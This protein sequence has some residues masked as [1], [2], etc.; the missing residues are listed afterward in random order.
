MRLSWASLNLFMKWMRKNWWWICFWGSKTLFNRP[1]ILKI[2][3]NQSESHYNWRFLKTNT[4][5]VSPVLMKCF[6]ISVSLFFT[7]TGKYFV[8][9]WIVRV[10]ESQCYSR[11]SQVLEMSGIFFFVLDVFNKPVLVW[12]HRPM[13]KPTVSLTVFHSIFV[14]L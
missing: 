1:S 8:F 5:V 12:N 14:V 11:S 10:L 9:G 4:A 3:W 2:C 7:C 13:M 6:I